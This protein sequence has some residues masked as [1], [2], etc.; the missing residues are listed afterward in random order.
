MRR[1]KYVSTE[2]ALYLL[3]YNMTRV[4]NIM[5]IPAMIAAMKTYAASFALRFAAQLTG[6]SQVA[7]SDP[8]IHCDRRN[9]ELI[10]KR[11]RNVEN[12]RQH[13]DQQSFHTASGHCYRPSQMLLRLLSATLT[14]SKQM[15]RNF[16]QFF[17]PLT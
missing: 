6:P 7:T 3:A 8:K 9:D 2:M 13:R 4:M 12:S 11:Y 14:S 16:L 17:D 5:G 10:P 15:V 1:L